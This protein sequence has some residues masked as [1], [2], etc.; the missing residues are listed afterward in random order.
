MS[1]R[2]RPYLKL[3][4][5]NFRDGTR[6][7]SRP[8][9]LL[10][11]ELIM[12]LDDQEG[13]IPDDL[14]WLVKNLGVHDSRVVRGPLE[15]LIAAGKI[16]RTKDGLT[17]AKVSADIGGDDDDEPEG[18]DGGGDAKGKVG[19]V[20]GAAL[21]TT[22]VHKPVEGLGTAEPLRPHYASTEPPLS[23]DCGQ[24]IAQA[25]EIARC[26]CGLSQSHSHSYIYDHEVVVAVPF[27]AARARGDPATAR[28]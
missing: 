9:K 23:S 19:A 6:M 11:F 3:W 15:E 21:P 20:E 5:A 26:F 2:K 4:K 10:Y 7:L 22:L 14:K 8:A 17:N 13:V 25:F 1:K 27:G 24:W 12:L 28:A 16:Q 18:K